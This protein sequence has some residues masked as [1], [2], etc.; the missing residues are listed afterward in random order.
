MPIA[1]PLDQVLRRPLEFALTSAIG[2]MHERDV[3]AARP[4][5]DGHPQGVA[6][7]AG[8]HVRRELPAD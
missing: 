4:R 2:V 5:R 7:Q 3:G 6:D 8:A 1:T